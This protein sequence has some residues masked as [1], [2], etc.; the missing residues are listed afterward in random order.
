[1][2][3]FPMAPAIAQSL[4]QA[5][6]RPQTPYYSEVSESIQRTYHP[7]GASTRRPSVPRPPR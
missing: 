6:P 2:K 4:Q 5:K 1:M 7:T 3:K